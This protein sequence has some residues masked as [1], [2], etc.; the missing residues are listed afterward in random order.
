MTCSDLCRHGGVL[1]LD[2]RRCDRGKTVERSIEI[3]N[4]KPEDLNAVLTLLA[5]VSLPGEGVLEHFQ[6]F[7]VAHEDGKLIGAIGMEPYGLSAL[8]RSLAVAPEYQGQGLGRALVERLLH[9]AREQGVKQIFLLTETA[10]EF[11]PKFGF[12][13]IAREETDAAVQQSVEFRTACCQSAGCMR[14]P[15]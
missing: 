12:T 3:R 6:H 7:L 4:G 1:T 2:D 11:F 13:C 14:L 9:Q 10:L 8:L 15:L 5:A